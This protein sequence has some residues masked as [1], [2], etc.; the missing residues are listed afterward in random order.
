MGPFKWCVEDPSNPD[1]DICHEL[2]VTIDPP[3]MIPDPKIDFT[4]IP[5]EVL[6]EIAVLVGIDRLASGVQDGRLRDQLGEAVDELADQLAAK[7]PSGV[8]L[9]RADVSGDVGQGKMS[10]S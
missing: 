5:D 4:I 3:R 1:E 7:L 9:R 8:A 6:T 2:F 10:G